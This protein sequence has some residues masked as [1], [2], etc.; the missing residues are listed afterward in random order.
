[1]SEIRTP[2]AALARPPFVF[3]TCLWGSGLAIGLVAILYDIIK[4]DLGVPTGRDF[5]NLYTAGTLALEGKAYEA[6]DVDTFRLA[7]REIIGTLTQQVYS[8][9]PHAMFVAVPFALLHY[10][11][12]LA[13]WSLLTLAFFYW[14][15]KPHVGF[16]PILAI[17]TPAAVL[18]I[19]C[20]QYGLLFGGL[21]LL[22]FRYLKDRPVN[23]GLVAAAMTF[24]P[25]L[26]LFIG[27]TA[28]T[29]WRVVAVAIAG[30][31]ALILTSAWA[32]GWA[33]WYGFIS[34][35]V[36]THVGFLTQQSDDFY[37]RLMPSAFTSYGRA[38]F[39]LV[40]QLAT[41]FAALVLIIRYRRIDPFVL[42]TATFL[43]VPYGFVYDMTV[44][45]LGFANMIWMQW[46]R[47]ANWERAVLAL[48]FLSP[49]IT[50]LY[51]RYSPMLVPP[52]LLLGLYIQTTRGAPDTAEA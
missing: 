41:A 8:Y 18:N 1:L 4:P 29:N 10:G 27:L 30:I 38:T 11:L 47:L 32:F 34:A 31:L 36:G 20:G 5:S 25:H 3:W 42:A 45:S 43:I 13:L 28:L 26:G 14:A 6:F 12:S 39:A 2:T 44:V 48:A 7:L 16:A 24:K 17:L 19:W 35:N 33:G 51:A 9:P 15:A 49:G 21:W 50:L 40:A 22:Y 52:I 37:F 23:A 46:R